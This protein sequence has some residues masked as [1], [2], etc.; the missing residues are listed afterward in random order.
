MQ[1]VMDAN[2]DYNERQ[3]R[4]GHEVLHVQNVTSANAD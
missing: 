4:L 2:A 3:C 1:I